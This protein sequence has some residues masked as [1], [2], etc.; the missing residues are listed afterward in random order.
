MFE[1]CWTPIGTQMNK[2]KWKF[3][4]KMKFI[5]DQVHS[6]PFGLLFLLKTDEIFSKNLQFDTGVNRFHFFQ[7]EKIH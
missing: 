7:F 4:E 6:N 5:C 1:K 3:R 2:N